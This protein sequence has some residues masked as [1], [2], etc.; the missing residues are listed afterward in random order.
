[1]LVIKG[2]RLSFERS[3]DDKYLQ[4]FDKFLKFTA[5][6]EIQRRSVM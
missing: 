6:L 3:L 2:N 1:M 5:F 4:Y